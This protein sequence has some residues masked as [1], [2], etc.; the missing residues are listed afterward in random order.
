MV[1]YGSDGA[2]STVIALLAMPG[3]RLF[4]SSRRGKKIFG[5]K[6]GG[7]SFEFIFLPEIFLPIFPLRGG[8]S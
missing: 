3:A 4:S 2:D 1:S 6:R 7:A 8:G 5:R